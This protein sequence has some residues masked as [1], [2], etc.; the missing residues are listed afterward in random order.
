MQTESDVDEEND[1][2]ELVEEEDT[3]D[4][5]PVV[6][7]ATRPRRS[8]CPISDSGHEIIPN[9]KRRVYDPDFIC[10]H[11]AKTTW[12]KREIEEL[13]TDAL[14]RE[15]ANRELC[16]RCREASPDSLPYGNE[17]GHVEWKPQFDKEGNDI[18]DDEGGLLYVAYPELVCDAG[19]KW[20][21]GEG[22]RRDTRGRN[23]ILFESHLYNRRRRELYAVEGVVDP[24]YTMD[25]WG[26]R[27][28]HGI[29]C[30]SHP[31]GRKTNTPEQRK[32]CGAGFY[33]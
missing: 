26:K 18:L 4:D 31:L 23:P 17:T 29:Y 3:D 32:K 5:T 12:T 6:E 9:Q 28:M 33:K 15:D 20:Y 27:T 8:P 25:R 7:V 16:K 2:L 21:L 11:C 14:L 1:E 30:R 19:H 10:K 24:A 22:P 13:I